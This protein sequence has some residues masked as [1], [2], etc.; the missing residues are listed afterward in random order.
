MLLTRRQLTPTVSVHG[1]NGVR[2]R[3]ATIN[4]LVTLV[5]FTSQEA[6][7]AEGSA[8]DLK[9]L[10]KGVKAALED[11]S[12]ATY[13]IL[14]DELGNPIGSISALKEWSDW[15][16]GYYWWIQ[17]MY[18]VPEQRGQGH[19]SNLLNAVEKEM[20]DQNGL[21]LRLYVHQHNERAIRAYEKVSFEKS[22][23]K[24]M[25]RKNEH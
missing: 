17:S 10:E 6:D 22:P 21:E 25:F 12:I 9:R 11:S 4:D 16:A 23:Y 14:I 15:H 8:K 13:W 3:K 2:V 18:I 1:D 20:K 5:D 24:I 7:E 19:M